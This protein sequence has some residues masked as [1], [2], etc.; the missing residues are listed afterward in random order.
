MKLVIAV[1]QGEDAER[2]VEALTHKGISSTRVSSSGGFLERSNVTLLIGVD[3]PQVDTALEV[4]R[5][6]C[7]ERT[8]YLTPMP[9][10]AEPGEMF[11]A[12]PVE[13]EVGGATV[14]VVP[15]ETFEKI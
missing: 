1:V 15:V 11:M 8:R 7:K 6:S 9:P 12:F 2:T 10:L 13:V 14:W 3:D 5:E 4:I